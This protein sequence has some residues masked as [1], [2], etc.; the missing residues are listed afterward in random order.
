MVDIKPGIYIEDLPWDFKTSL[1]FVFPSIILYRMR[2][3]L[4]IFF[5]LGLLGTSLAIVT[6]S[7]LTMESTDNHSKGPAEEKEDPPADE[8]IR[9]VV[10]PRKGS[11]N[12]TINNV[13]DD[14]KKISEAE[15]IYSF[16]SNDGIFRW[17]I[18]HATPEQLKEIKEHKEIRYAAPSGKMVEA[19]VARHSFERTQRS[20]GNDTDLGPL[21]V[22]EKRDET[23]AYEAQLKAVKELRQISIPKDAN[24]QDGWPDYVYEKA[25]GEGIYIYHVEMVSCH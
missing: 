7:N 25:A 5:F 15:K 13:E 1:R 19:R 6:E 4:Y 23:Q 8:K 3:S 20:F 11:D 17:W 18:V 10:A 24:D 9:C 2:P 21:H 22:L 12:A 16:T 14:L